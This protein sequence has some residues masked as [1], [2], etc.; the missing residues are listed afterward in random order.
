MLRNAISNHFS[1]SYAFL[2]KKS[3]SLKNQHISE[4]P[5]KGR[6]F[7]KKVLNNYNLRTIFTIVHNFSIEIMKMF[8][9]SWKS[10]TITCHCSPGSDR[11]QFTFLIL[12]H[13]IFQDRG[14]IDKCVQCSGIKMD[15]I[16]LD[17]HMYSTNIFSIF[18]LS[19][20]DVTHLRGRGIC[21]K[22]T[23]LHKPIQ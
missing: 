2:T 11:K 17:L 22:V 14:I 6:I 21:Q 7:N 19:I 23:L 20:N 12:G 9:I 16:N 8:G 1:L 18:G 13:Q 10:C 15:P 5:K 4:W 3:I